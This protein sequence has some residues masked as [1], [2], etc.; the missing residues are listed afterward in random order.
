MEA[1]TIG[2]LAKRAGV[3]VETIRFYERQGLIPAP[4]RSDSGY[5]RYPADTADRLRFIQR[6][7]ELGFSLRE[8]QHLISL[9]LDEGAS[10]ADV[11]LQAEEK[12]REIDQRIRDLERMRSSLS[13]L[14]DA[15]AGTMATDGCPILRA[16]SER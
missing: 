1:M 4:P 2:R 3:G 16:I 13:A 15:C 9:R 11:K 8:I 5:R 12:I 14:V 6:A 7:K 10:A